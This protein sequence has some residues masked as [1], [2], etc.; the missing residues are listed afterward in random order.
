M[1]LAERDYHVSLTEKDIDT[2]SFYAGKPTPAGVHLE[3]GTLVGG[4]AIVLAKS[5]HLPIITVGP[6]DGPEY[7]DMIANNIAK[8]GLTDRI[9][10]YPCISSEYEHAGYS[11]GLL[12]IDGNHS[13]EWVLHDFYKFSRFVVVGGY[14]AF[15]DYEF[16]GGVT[17]FVKSLEISPLPYNLIDVEG[18]TAVFK[19]VG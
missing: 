5:S 2:L 10:H 4:G 11:I 12:F 16:D 13:F 7:K 15:H 14:V 3:I 18:Y 1:K 6:Y 9:T 19:K 8:Q 17:A